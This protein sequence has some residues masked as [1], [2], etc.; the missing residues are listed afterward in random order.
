[1]AEAEMST[2]MIQFS[3]TTDGWAALVRNPEDRG[4]ALKG[5]AERLGGRFLGLYY[6]FGEYDGFT[7]C[8]YPDSSTAMASVLAAIGPGHVRATRTT[9]LLSVAEAMQAMKK[10]GSIAFQGPKR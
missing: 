7:L 1:M 8:D 4:V 5:L 2:Y 3:L 9:V 10:A 6:T